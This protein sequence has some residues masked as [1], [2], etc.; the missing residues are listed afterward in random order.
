MV[1]F[2]ELNYKFLYYLSL[3]FRSVLFFL[4]LS[5][6]F[7]LHKYKQF[8]II[9]FLAIIILTTFLYIFYNSV[10]GTGMELSVSSVT[11]PPQYE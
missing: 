2:R 10:T 8:N 4:T 9:S 7:V 11:Y 3:Y 6:A 1:S 5:A